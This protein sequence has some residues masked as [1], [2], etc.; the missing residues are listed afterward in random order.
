MKSKR[1]RYLISGGKL[2]PAIIRF[3]YS[4]Y[5]LKVPN[6]PKTCESARPRHDHNIFRCRYAVTGTQMTREELPIWRG[7]NCYSF[8]HRLLQLKNQSTLYYRNC[9]SIFSGNNMIRV[10]VHYWDFWAHRLKKYLF[11]YPF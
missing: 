4:E 11:S 1:I 9:K 7:T 10:S 2:L 3:T 6:H 8:F 5:T